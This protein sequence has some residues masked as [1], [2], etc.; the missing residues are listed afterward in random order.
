MRYTEK[1][2]HECREKG[3]MC[4]V[5]LSINYWRYNIHIFLIL[6][7]PLHENHLMKYAYATQITYN[8]LSVCVN[9]LWCGVAVIVCMRV[10]LGCMYSTIVHSTRARI[11]FDSFVSLWNYASPAH[12]TYARCSPR[13][14]IIANATTLMIGL[15]LLWVFRHGSSVVS[16]TFQRQ[17][18]TFIL[19]VCVK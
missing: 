7:R 9:C 12:I 2:S 15:Q 17:S 19:Y 13:S 4:D 16:Y 14:F 10:W 5:C 11:I 18:H 3:R 6:P 8:K 1:R